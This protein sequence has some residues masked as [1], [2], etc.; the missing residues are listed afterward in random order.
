MRD[1]QAHQ[2]G[3]RNY[4]EASVK[5]SNDSGRMPDCI[6]IPFHFSEYGS[7]LTG[8]TQRQV[9]VTGLRFPLEDSR[10]RAYRNATQLAHTSVSRREDGALGT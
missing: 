1:T 3:S 6:R 4:I 10:E 5:I 2:A 7:V 8:L 9:T